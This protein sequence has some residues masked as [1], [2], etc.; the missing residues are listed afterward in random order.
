M[1]KIRHI[2]KRA[3]KPQD[4]VRLT[5]GSA[6]FAGKKPVEYEIDVCVPDTKSVPG[7]KIRV[8]MD[9]SELDALINDLQRQRT[10]QN[11]VEEGRKY[12]LDAFTP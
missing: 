11:R 5:A 6:S 3:S 4:G 9:Q 7:Y 2:R 10:Y 12:N 1:A 8:T